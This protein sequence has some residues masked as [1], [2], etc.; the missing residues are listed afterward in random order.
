MR[1]IKVPFLFVAGDY[2]LIN[3]NQTIAIFTILPQNRLFI[4]PSASYIVPAENPELINSEV[5]KFLK[6]PYRDIDG[7]CFF[8]LPK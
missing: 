7:Y 5:I 3:I 6:T 1:Q 8:K 4:V 2:D